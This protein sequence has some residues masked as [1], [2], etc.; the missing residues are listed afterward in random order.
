M[1]IDGRAKRV[2]LNDRV[3]L[4]EQWSRAYDWQRNRAL[5]FHAPVGSPKR[6]LKRLPEILEDRGWALTMQSGASL[7]APHVSWDQIH[8]YVRPQDE[9]DILG[10]AQAAGWSTSPEGR[11][12]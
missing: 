11:S 6:F 5:S 1:S 3:A 8:I 10:I 2:Q 7:V 12:S 4:I 9:D